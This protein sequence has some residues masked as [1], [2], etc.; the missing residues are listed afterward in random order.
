M[1]TPRG[2]LWVGFGTLLCPRPRPTN[3]GSSWNRCALWTRFWLRAPATRWSCCRWSWTRFPPA[4]GWRLAACCFATRRPKRW[5][6]RWARALPY[7]HL[8]LGEGLIGSAVAEGRTFHL[9]GAALLRDG[10]TFAHAPRLADEGF[11]S[12]HAVPLVT[13]GVV[14]G[15]LELFRHEAADFGEDAGA[16]VGDLAVRAALAIERAALREE[17]AQH[18]G[19][20]ALDR[21]A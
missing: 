7:S 19:G 9:A 14:R 13:N 16:F 4:S 20:A 5:N 3:Q 21:A 2:M 10:E 1:R 12:Y 17:L 15:V 11:G 18:G 6:T 8:H